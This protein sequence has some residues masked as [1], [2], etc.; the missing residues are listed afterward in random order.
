MLFDFISI[1]W[2]DLRGCLVSFLPFMWI[3]KGMFESCLRGYLDGFMV[4]FWPVYGRFYGLFK[5]LFGSFLRGYL[6]LFMA[7][8]G[9]C[10]GR[11][12]G[13]FKG[14]FGI[15]LRGCLGLFY[16]LFRS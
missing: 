10:Y 16:G 15:C 3:L 5:G 7:Y 1:L 14:L 9:G 13:M 2:V 6:G 12:C 4:V 8:L 11:F